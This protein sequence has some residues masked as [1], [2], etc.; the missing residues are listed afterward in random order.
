MDSY[1]IRS[2]QHV[3]GHMRDGEIGGRVATQQAATALDGHRLGGKRQGG[4]TDQPGKDVREARD[5][6]PAHFVQY[7]HLHVGVPTRTIG[8]RA[9]NRRHQGH[10]C[11]VVN[12]VDRLPQH[13]A[14]DHSHKG[15]AHQ[16]DG[17]D[18]AQAA[19]RID[20]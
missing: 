7:V 16:Q 4:D 10:L 12:P 17:S 2:Q 3:E 19:E 20:W 13:I 18:R 15:D 9:S 1:L 5:V 8:Q 14:P 6:S 11:D